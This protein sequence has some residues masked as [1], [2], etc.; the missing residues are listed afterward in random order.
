MYNHLL[1]TSASRPI[2]DGNY[3]ACH[4]HAARKR[5][6]HRERAAENRESQV[7]G[8]SCV[9][10]SDGHSPKKRSETFTVSLL[11]YVSKQILGLGA[12]KLLEGNAVGADNQ[13]FLRVVGVAE[14]GEA[15]VCAVVAALHFLT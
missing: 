4:H 10:I 6:L 13:G 14:D 2:Q 7:V 12:Q 8:S 3:T 15:L 5:N 1:Q 9:K 11:F